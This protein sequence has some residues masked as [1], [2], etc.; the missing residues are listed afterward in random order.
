MSSANVMDDVTVN[1]TQATGVASACEAVI[2]ALSRHTPAHAAVLLEIGDCLRCVAAVGSWHVFSAVPLG[3]GIAGRV[4]AANMTA[5]ITDTARDAAYVPLGPAVAVEICSPIP[6]PGGPAGVLNLEWTEPIEIDHWQ[7][8]I[9]KSAALLGAR[10]TELGGPPDESD[11]ERALRHCVAFA[12]APTAQDLREVSL[13]AAREVSGLSTAVLV[14]RTPLVQDIYVDEASPTALGEY[15]KSLSLADLAPMTALV[16]RYGASYTLGD[17]KHFDTE[18]YDDIVAAGARTLVAVPIGPSPTDG[19]LLLMMDQQVHRPSGQTASLLSLLATHAWT[20]LDRLRTLRMLRERASSDPLTGLRHH[21]PFGER[22]SSSVP[23][24][25]AVLAIDVDRFKDVNDT[26]GHLV[27][28]QVLVQVAE[29]LSAALRG[30]VDNLYRIGGDEFAVVI[31]VQRVEEAVGI[32]ERLVAAARAIGRTIS[33][34]VAVR[35]DDE[36]AQDTLRRADE[37]LYVAKRGG[38]DTV[39]LAI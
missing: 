1:L 9:E 17:P 37:A 3:A 7:T 22:L 32:A 14:L 6:G 18:G 5:V 26:Y 15:A 20:S 11:S 33:I 2:D 10:L 39:R 36:S 23:G 19:G 29:A 13:R 12:E 4:H 35:C 28:D 38:R 16:H 24:S 31:E 34:G 30:G 27:G 21:G 8:V 25:T